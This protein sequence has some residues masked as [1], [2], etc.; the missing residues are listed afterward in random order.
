MISVVNA[1]NTTASNSTSI[2]LSHNVPSV[3]E[4][5]D[6]EDVA[7][8]NMAMS[9]EEVNSEVAPVAS[10]ALTKG[11][12]KVVASVTE[13]VEV[14]DAAVRNAAMNL[15]EVNPEGVETN[16]AGNYTADKK[17]NAKY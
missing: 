4:D 10:A 16:I 6:T 3:I 5:V 15:E 8:R 7:V 11:F 13:D 2:V 17:E 14:A 12:A 1:Q 9:L